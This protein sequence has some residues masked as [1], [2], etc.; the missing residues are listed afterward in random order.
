MALH[1]NIAYFREKAGLS[2]RELADR[3]GLSPGII[4][5]YETNRK[6]PRLETLRRL[7]D[8]LGTSVAEL[9]SA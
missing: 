4:G 7:A 1:Q 3:A 5:Q 9:L 2:Q 8:A 6:T